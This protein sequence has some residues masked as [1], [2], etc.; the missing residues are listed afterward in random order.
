MIKTVCL[1]LDG[2]LSIYD[3]WRGLDW[4]GEPYPGAV[5]FTRELAQTCK[6][7]I[8]TTR[9]K[10]YPPD[11]P[12]PEGKPEPNRSEPY[13]LAQIVRK[14]LDKHGFS[15]HEIYV[16]QGK[17]I[18]AA[19]VDDR[20]IVCRPKETGEW[21]FKVALRGIQRLFDD[22]ETISPEAQKEEDSK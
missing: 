9:C 20:A 17:P 6:V 15:Y 2:V 4:I 13:V 1:D 10:S 16:G 21:A 3:G 8:Y 14:W 19:Y 18:A 22:Q 12:G 11:V 5:E 7:V